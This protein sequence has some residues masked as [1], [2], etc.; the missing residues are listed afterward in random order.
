MAAFIQFFW[1]AMLALQEILIAS[2]ALERFRTNNISI[3]ENQ[4]MYSS[5]NV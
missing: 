3:F 1:T 2:T 5:E 4:S